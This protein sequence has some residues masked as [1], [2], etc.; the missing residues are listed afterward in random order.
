[1]KGASAPFLDEGRKERVTMVR[2]AV[3]VSLV[4]GLLFS[5]VVF[6]QAVQAHGSMQTPISRVYSCYLENPET[7][8][9]VVC[10]DAIAMG[11]TQ[12]LYD[13]NEIHLLNAA[14]NHRAL[15]PDGKLCSAGQTKYAAFD[16][17]RTD[18]ATTILPA[19][20]NYTFVF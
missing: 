5:S 16:Q 4:L 15:I 13:W 14:G 6:I 9:T 19:S 1:M 3:R 20:G 7:P 12:A 8:D 11:G 2:S 10:R 17:P 18:W